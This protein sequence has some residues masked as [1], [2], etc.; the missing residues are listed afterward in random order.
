[1]TRSSFPEESTRIER[2]CFPLRSLVTFSI[3]AF[4]LRILKCG[5][6]VVVPV[7]DVSSDDEAVGHQE[8]D[9]DERSDEGDAVSLLIASTFLLAKSISPDPPRAL[10]LAHRLSS[11]LRSGGR[12]ST[13]SAWVLQ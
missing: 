8:L 10:P 4:A 13:H 2:T 1:M 12:V 5:S 3:C 9:H 7:A 11:Y 6:M